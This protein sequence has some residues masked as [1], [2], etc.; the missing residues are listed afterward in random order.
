MNMMKKMKN[1]KYHKALAIVTVMGIVALG[2]L[3]A[4]PI[5]EEQDIPMEVTPAAEASSEAAGILY[6]RE[7]EKLARDVYLALYEVW[8]IRTFSNIAKS[9]Q[10]HMDAVALLI[11]KQGLVDPA[12]DT[13]PGEFM[14][15]DLASLYASLVELGSQSPQDA[16]TV[17][18]IIEDLDISDLQAYLLK[19]EDPYARVVYANLLKGSE[20]HIRS[21]T[22]QLSR[23]GIVYEARYL[24]A[25]RLEEILYRQVGKR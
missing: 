14:N 23:Y 5:G 15:P 18:A 13:K 2:S 21:F 16:L 9:E 25:E 24:T 1:K 19:T 12:L 10:K 20:N 6:M 7:E 22:R 4:Q 3:G 11:E 17:G 8:G